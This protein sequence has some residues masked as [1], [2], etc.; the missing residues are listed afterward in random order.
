[1][2]GWGPPSLTSQEG[3][4]WYRDSLCEAHLIWFEERDYWNWEVRCDSAEDSQT[5]AW[6]SIRRWVSANGPQLPLRRSWG[7]WEWREYEHGMYA[8]RL[9]IVLSREEG[10]AAEE[11]VIFGAVSEDGAE[12]TFEEPGSVW[13][14]AGDLF[15]WVTN[16]GMA[17]LSERFVVQP[18]PGG[19]H[20]PEAAACIRAHG[21]VVLSDVL[22]E[23]QIAEL[24]RGCQE[25]EKEFLETDRH[26][27]GHRGPGRYSFGQT[28][29]HWW[30][31][32][33]EARREWTDVAGLPAVAA[34]VDELLGQDALCV[35]MGG[36]FVL[37][38]TSHSQYLHSDLFGWPE[39]G[40]DSKFGGRC[41]FLS[42]NFT[43]RPV[44]ARD[45]PMRMLPGTHRNRGSKE[46]P[47]RDTQ[48]ARCAGVAPLPAGAAIFRDVRTWHS[49][50]PNLGP[51]TR[52]LPSCEYVPHAYL[53]LLS[54]RSLH[55]RW[56]SE[57]YKPQPGIMPPELYADLSEEG[58][59]LCRYLHQR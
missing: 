27:R 49:G 59:R 34:V 22:S 16:Q 12:I 39:A 6:H 54:S 42:V 47:W 40:D 36:D 53:E 18:R 29:R 26:R 4:C 37:P 13:S 44:Y 46:L 48:S 17:G 1:M 11:Y 41:P 55:D 28:R 51:R 15:D 57:H 56:N 52:Y 19:A 10:F 38:G 23:S 31:T 9:R 2:S 45:G 43:V 50:T 33:C 58:K 3:C 35:S 7:N 14:R 8:W 21:F 5:Y 30:V 25:L 20:A 24:L 32:P